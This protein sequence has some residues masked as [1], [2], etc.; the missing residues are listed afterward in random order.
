MRMNG[1]FYSENE[2][3]ERLNNNN[4]P[5]VK[6]NADTCAGCDELPA[7][8]VK[9]VNPWLINGA[10]YEQRNPTTIFNPSSYYSYTADTANAALQTKIINTAGWQNVA[11]PTATSCI[12]TSLNASSAASDTGFAY[13]IGGNFGT[14]ADSSTTTSTLRLFENSLELGPAHS[15]HVDIRTLGQGRFSHKISTTGGESL[16]FSASN[17][18]DPRTNGKSYSYC[19]LDTTP[20]TVPT[21]LTAVASA[22][23]VSLSWNASS[24]IGVTGYRVYRNGT[25][26]AAPASNSYI[27]GNL[28]PGTYSYTVAAVD[29]AGNVSAQS[30]SVSATVFRPPARLRLSLLLMVSPLPSQVQAQKAMGTAPLER[31]SRVVRQPPARDSER[32][33]YA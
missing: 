27:D 5:L 17:N 33:D 11:S 3:L 18:T 30:G 23:Q 28:V 2:I 22:S 26:I 19:I 24:G 1:Q 31:H 25:Q 13:I 16:R 9:V 7:A 20:P 6:A 4:Y 29:A 10:T 12:T 8:N 32:H 14:P 15:L 21:G